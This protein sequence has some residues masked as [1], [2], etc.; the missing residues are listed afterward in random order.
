MVRR[1]SPCRYEVNFQSGMDCGGAYMKLLSDTP[2]LNLVRGLSLA[3]FV[4]T[5][6][7]QWL[8]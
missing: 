1:S 4:I 7:V 3:S 8:S 5:G 6:V 2:Q